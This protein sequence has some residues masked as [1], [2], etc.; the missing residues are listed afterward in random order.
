MV[1]SIPVDMS[2]EFL[3]MELADMS[4][5]IA[6]LIQDIDKLGGHRWNMKEELKVLHDITLFCH[7]RHP[8]ELRTAGSTR[9]PAEDTQ[10]ASTRQHDTRVA[11]DEPGQEKTTANKSNLE[12]ETW[13]TKK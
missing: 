10:E 4:D 12:D 13:Q 6:K 11:T 8:P 3:R 2:Y 9:G 7:E 5:N 1:T